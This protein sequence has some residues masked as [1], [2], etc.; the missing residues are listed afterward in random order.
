MCFQNFKK[1]K[2]PGQGQKPT[3]VVS[4][5]QLIPLLIQLDKKFP[6]V[7]AFIQAVGNTATRYVG[8]D[9]SMGEELR[10]I[11]A[12]QE[13]LPHD[14]P[15]RAMGEVVESGAV[16]RLNQ[17]VDDAK[18]GWHLERGLSRDITKAKDE[19]IHDASR[20]AQIPKAQE[21]S[22]HTNI[23]AQTSRAA[24]GDTPIAW[25]MAH[26]LARDAITRNHMTNNQ[27][28]M[29]R[30]L[31]MATRNYFGDDSISIQERSNKT[32][33]AAAQLHDIC[34]DAGLHEEFLASGPPLLNAA[35]STAV[36][37]K[38]GKNQM[39]LPGSGQIRR[40]KAALEG[41]EIEAK[42]RAIKEKS[43]ANKRRRIA[44]A[45][46][47][48]PQPAPPVQQTIYKF[49]GPVGTVNTTNNNN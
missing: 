40:A 43:S 34:K 31:D 26:G 9:T 23:N 47:A 3:W 18:V 5:D 46:A 15:M 39:L 44:A 4:G 41:K 48:P 20:R 24:I 32:L 38:G 36:E 16:G 13:Q 2:F 27:L 21:R 35:E 30:V 28:N 6:R 45:P 10:E 19:A 11:R 7:A 37:E 29:V 8:G 22:L 1:H 33:R 25:K 49:F 42:P 14:H 12:V 17:V